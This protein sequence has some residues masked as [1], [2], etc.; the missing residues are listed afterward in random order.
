M[1]FV[2]SAVLS[3]LHFILSLLP[4]AISSRI[5]ATLF[6]LNL[7]LGIR[8][9]APILEKTATLAKTKSPASLFCQPNSFPSA[10]ARTIVII[11][12]LSATGPNDPRIA[13][14]A[15]AFA[16]ADPRNIVIVPR[17]APLVEGNL[18]NDAVGC[19]RRALEDV[20]GCPALCPSG[21]L[22]IASPCISAGYSIVAATFYDFVDALFCIGPHASVHNTL[23]HAL[24]RKGKDDS[25][26]GINSVLSSYMHPPCPPLSEMLAAY[27]IDDHKQ[28]LNLESNEVQRLQQKYP[29]HVAEY[30]RLHEDDGYLATKLK[31]LYEIH[32]AEF[33]SQSPIL[34]L[35]KLSALSLTLVH[36][37][38]DDIVPPS[39]SLLLRES[40]ERLGGVE[41]S[42]LIT[43]LLNH[44]DQKA[45]GLGD[46]MSIVA[47]IDCFSLFFRTPSKASGQRD[48]SE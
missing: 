20:V 39:E 37:E 3:A 11:H 22:S 2:V 7:G 32:K 35:E 18:S 30:N 16:S 27:C 43:P 45:I 15:R 4:A 1:Q 19:I 34:H 44:G 46:A 48:R 33:D 25:R 10:H 6:A 24:E 36:A 23:I 12:G 42:C 29:E 38:E 31:E 28:N 9:S 21:T 41:V 26:Y 8:V 40:L 14:L 5:Y 17:I 47:L 13:N